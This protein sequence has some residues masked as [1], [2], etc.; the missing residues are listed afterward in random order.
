MLR[1]PLAIDLAQYAAEY[2]KKNTRTLGLLV[3][4]NRAVLTS[5]QGNWSSRRESAA[6]LRLL[7]SELHE[8]AWAEE[9]ERRTETIARYAAFGTAE[10][11][12]LAGKIQS[13]IGQCGREDAVCWIYREKLNLVRAELR[14]R[15]SGRDELPERDECGPED[16]D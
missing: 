14:H 16:D 7:L 8:R 6:K 4:S 13:L 9:C 3:V 1:H 15:E 10:L 12:K 2:A 5:S 11:E